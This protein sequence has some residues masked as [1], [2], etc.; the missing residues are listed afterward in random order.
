MTRSTLRCTVASFLLLLFSLTALAA[1]A[2]VRTSVGPMTGPVKSPP[3]L[4]FFWN[5]LIR[6]WEKAGSSLDPD[7]KPQTSPNSG[8]SLDPSGFLPDNGGSLDP[9]GVK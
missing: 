7:G 6:L 1:A 8:S 5:Q 4:S 9:S 2:P 3:N